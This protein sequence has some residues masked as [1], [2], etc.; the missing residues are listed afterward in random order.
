MG[1]VLDSLSTNAAVHAANDITSGQGIALA[2]DSGGSPGRLLLRPHCV[3]RTDNS[4]CDDLSANLLPSRRTAPGTASI[5]HFTGRHCCRTASGV[6]K[7]CCNPL[8]PSG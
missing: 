7:K 8:Q 6:G 5:T 2:A 4:E 3:S 1:A